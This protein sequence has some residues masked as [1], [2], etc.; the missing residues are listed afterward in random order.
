[1]NKAGSKADLDDFW[2]NYLAS[3]SK[4]DITA[5]KYASSQETDHKSRTV[6]QASTGIFQ[7]LNNQ[8]FFLPRPTSVNR[9]RPN[10]I[11][12]IGAMGDSLTAANGAKATN[13]QMMSIEDRG[14]SWSMGGENPNINLVV[15]LPSIIREFKLLYI[16][17]LYYYKINCLISQF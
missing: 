5:H 14:V 8:L 1:M 9:L 16:A 12:V 10:D 7:C 2:P 4:L 15:T 11:E 13:L 3:I 17:S 6:L